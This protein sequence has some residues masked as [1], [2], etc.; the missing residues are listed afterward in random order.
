M[1]SHRKEAQVMFEP[2]CFYFSSVSPSFLML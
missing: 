2:V 1:V